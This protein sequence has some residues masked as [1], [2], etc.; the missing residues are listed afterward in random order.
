MLTPLAS[1][2]SPPVGEWQ[3]GPVP[4]RAYAICILLGIVVA[5]WMLERRYTARGGPRDTALDVAF[6]MVPAGIVG[7]R[8]YHVLS[9]PDAYFGPDGNLVR[10]LFIWQGGLGIWGAVAAGAVAAWLALRR[11]GLRLGPF[12]DALAPALLVAQAIGRLGNWF[13]QELYGGPT[14]LP[15]GLEIDPAHLVGGYPPGTLFHP[16]FLYE[17]VWNLL[18]AFVLIRLEKRFR[19]GGGRVFW[20]YV[21]LYTLGRVWIEMLRIDEAE[22]VLGLRLNVWTSIALFVVALVIFVVLGRR[23]ARARENGTGTGDRL[24]DR[25]VDD[26]LDPVVQSPRAAAVESV[27]LPGREPVTEGTDDAEDTAGTTDDAEDRGDTPRRPEEVRTG[28]PAGPAGTAV[29]SDAGDDRPESRGT[30]TH[31]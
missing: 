12:A 14:T 22:M 18:A 28:E 11:K 31:P 20:L 10:A 7:A 15:W 13:N 17:L 25:V 16:T 4:I 9:S 23:Q 6:W 21:M 3:L 19:L 24:V 1:L 8:I 5:L 26:R 27:W 2:P 29:D 30:T